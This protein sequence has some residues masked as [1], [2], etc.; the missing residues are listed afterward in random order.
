VID[1]EKGREK[2]VSVYGGV[3]YVYKYSM[4]EPGID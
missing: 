2:D 4:Y 3:V 1:I